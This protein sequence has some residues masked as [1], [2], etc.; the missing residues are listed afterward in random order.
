MKTPRFLH[1]KPP[2]LPVWKLFSTWTRN[3]AALSV[4]LNALEC[5]SCQGF[6]DAFCNDVISIGIV[7]FG[8]LSSLLMQEMAPGGDVRR[9]LMQRAQPAMTSTLYLQHVALVR[10]PQGPTTGP[11]IVS[12]PW[13][14]ATQHT[15][16]TQTKLWTLLKNGSSSEWEV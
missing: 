15:Q 16:G 11:T 14:Q 12:I 1:E 5:L 4:L 8:T 9:E 10:C 7:L 13:S 3:V 2:L 6:W